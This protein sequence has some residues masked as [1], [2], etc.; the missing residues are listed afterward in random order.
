MGGL[1]CHLPA[2]NGDCRPGAPPYCAETTRELGDCAAVKS[3][4]IK[5]PRAFFG[6]AHKSAYGTKQTSREV[7]SLSA[8]LIGRSGSSAFRLLSTYASMSLTGSCF[9]SE[10]APGPFHHGIRRRGDQSN[11]RPCLDGRQV[12][13]DTRSHLIHRPARDILPPLACARISSY[14]I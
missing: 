10:S 6:P 11:G 5:R 12:Q 3:R 1:I 8:S 13:A 4:R 14:R 2:Q 7:C 9:S